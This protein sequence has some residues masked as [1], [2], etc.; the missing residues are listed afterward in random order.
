MIRRPC[1]TSSVEIVVGA[2]CAPFFLISAIPLIWF[3][4]RMTIYEKIIRKLWPVLPSAMQFL[5]Q[6]PVVPDPFGGLHPKK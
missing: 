4:D 5:N 3:A 1:C 6:V 2:N